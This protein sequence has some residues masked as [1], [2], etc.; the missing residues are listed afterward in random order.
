MDARKLTKILITLGGL[1]VVGAVVWWY[2]FYTHL[3]RPLRSDLTDVIP[4]I[5]SS[6][7]SCGLVSG[8]AS[9]GGSTP[10][11]P[12]V[13]WVGVAVLGIGLAFKLALKE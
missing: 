2:Y 3:A 12:M 5:Y 4:C 11:E 7:G 10:Y 6:G 13:L 8:L 9:F 1:T